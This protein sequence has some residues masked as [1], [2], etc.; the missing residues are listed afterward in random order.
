MTRRLTA[1]LAGLSAVLALAAPASA[2]PMV[3]DN[4]APFL[5]TVGDGTAEA[6]MAYESSQSKTLDQLFYRDRT[7]AQKL[8]LMRQ[9]LGAGVPVGQVRQFYSHWRSDFDVVAS[10]MEQAYGP[11]SGI[12]VSA[13]YCAD[14][15]F[16]VY[17]MVDGQP[18]L[19]LNA[20]PMM[21]YDS[22]RTR[23]MIARELFRYYAYQTSTPTPEEATLSR[24]VQF[25]GLSMAAMQRALPGLA[26]HQYLMVPAAT[27]KAWERYQTTIARGLKNALDRPESANAMERFFG[28]GFGDPWP[29]GA[30]RYMAYHLGR[31]AAKDRGALELNVLPSRDYLFSV[32]SA[33]DDWAKVGEGLKP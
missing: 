26:P 33:L 30:G 17:G 19:A 20:R 13:W 8:N 29:A 18:T 28:R 32:Q 9:A 22:T 23:L 16:S 14:P 12:K 27:Y 31:V 24:R 3:E 4:L 15:R 6:W 10:R 21:P 5:V 7:P 1:M 11:L 2:M 25:E